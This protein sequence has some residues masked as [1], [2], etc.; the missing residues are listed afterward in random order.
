MEG[1]RNNYRQPTL[2][3]NKKV[4]GN[5][6]GRDHDSVKGSSKNRGR[7]RISGNHSGSGRVMG[8]VWVGS[9]GRTLAV[10][11]TYDHICAYRAEHAEEV[12]AVTLM[13]AS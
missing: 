2:N 5:D 12:V 8:V 7:H 13:L 9:T 1:D 11:P 4:G 3:A 6:W 10:P